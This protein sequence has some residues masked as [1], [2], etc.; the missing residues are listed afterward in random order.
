MSGISV[1]SLPVSDAARRLGVSDQRVRAM[2]SVGAVDAQKVAGAWWIS[3][4][5]LARAVALGRPA[6][7]PFS[8]ESAWSLLLI[9][10]GELVSWASPRVRW[11]ASVA[12]KEKGLAESFGK[13]GNRAARHA[14]QAHPA[15]LPRL[16]GREDLM[17]GGVSAAGTH[18]LGLQGGNEVE[19]YVAADAIEH[20][21]QRHGLVRGSEANVV[22]RAI[23][24]DMWPFLHSPVA[25]LAVVLADLAEHTDPRARRVGHERAVRLDSARANG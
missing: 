12:L 5:S 2:I 17:L 21:A 18:R 10:S 11:R 15:E 3:A 24:E 8:P 9:A 19:A 6:G 25:P 16:A 22:L 4:E 20:V 13:L 1:P 7:R 14:F 23:P